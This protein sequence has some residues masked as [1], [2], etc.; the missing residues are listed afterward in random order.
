MGN[1][2]ISALPVATALQGEENIVVVQ[3]GVTTKSTVQNIVN[4]IVPTSL[5]V[6]S[7]QTINLSD[8]AYATSELIELSWSGSNGTMVL[9][10]PLAAS[11]VN[12]VMRFI[13]NTGFG[14]GTQNADLTPQGGDTLDGSTNKY[15]INKEYEGIQVWSNGVEWYII[16][17]KA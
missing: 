7:G 10:L 4:Y 2:K 9:N 14:A 11:N 13:S 8:S 15:R 17:K 6:S 12:R 16:Q 1:L 5:T 3:G